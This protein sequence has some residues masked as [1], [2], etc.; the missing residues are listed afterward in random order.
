[1]VSRSEG[2][3]RG[4]S[5]LILALVG[6]AL[7]TAC[8]SSA[9]RSLA[10]RLHQPGPLN[11][12]VRVL[13]GPGTDMG[14]RP[15]VEVRVGNGPLVPV[16]LD[17]GGS[18][19]E[20]YPSGLDLR[21]GGGVAVTSH[22]F[23]VAYGDGSIQ[24]GSVA[25]AKVAVGGVTT[26]RSIK[27]GVIQSIECA[28]SK[29]HCPLDGISPARG[30][31]GVLGTS[32][33]EIQPDLRNPLIELPAP[34][35][36]SWSIHLAGLHGALTLGAPLPSNPVAEFQLPAESSAQGQAPAFDDAA[37]PVCWRFGNTR[38]C[39]PTL[40]DTGSNLTVWFGP[41]WAD[42]RPY[43]GAG[44]AVS[45]AEEGEGR[46]FWSFSSGTGASEDVVTHSASALEKV[47]T[48]V[49]AFYALK[50]TYD[51]I[52]GRLFLTASGAPTNRA[53]LSNVLSEA[54]GVC[55]SASEETRRFSTEA[56]PD[57]PR[58]LP[59]VERAIRSVIRAIANLSLRADRR[60][61]QLRL[62]PGDMPR[63]D[64][65]VAF[66]DAEAHQ[67]L[68][69]A[70]RLTAYHTWNAYNRAGWNFQSHFRMAQS[71]WSSDMDQLGIG[72]C[73]TM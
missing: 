55:V 65:A 13:G 29:P 39:L 42:G 10:G 60:L 7:C 72:G 54:N 37:A 38:H 17:T 73:T 9:P 11:V 15:V 32:L 71:N 8:A 12:P 41:V 2:M 22:R 57:N 44:T 18:G 5:L 21:T 52:H 24:R 63:F 43:L 34:Y 53:Q 48:G 50:I 59:S 46:P 20:M 26:D 40:F 69:F 49:Q 45:A 35:S 31:Y 19:L 64:R 70:N 27:F 47:N 56:P 1:M 14:A 66:R 28:R 61:S 4:G 58:D 68:N 62:P 36:R 3:R 16:L 33:H 6:I 67:M 51:P 23:G 30:L 25:S